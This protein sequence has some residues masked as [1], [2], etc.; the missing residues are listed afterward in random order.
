[1]GGGMGYGGGSVGGSAAAGISA[2]FQMGREVDNDADRR[3]QVARENA[4]QDMLDNERQAQ[5]TRNNTRQDAEDASNQNVRAVAAINGEMEDNRFQLANLA[6]KYGGAANVPASLAAPFVSQA[7]DISQRRTALLQQI[8]APVV[9]REQQWA[10]DTSSRIAAG[11]ISM[12]SLSPADTVRLYQATTRR[13]VSDFLRPDTNDPAVASDIANGVMSGNSVV[14]QGIADSE[15]GVQSGNASLAAR[16]A[17]T[18]TAPEVSQGVGHIATDGSQITGKTISALVPAP[19]A[20]NAT[21]PAPPGGVIG[22]LGAALNGT[23]PATSLPVSATSAS[24]PGGLTGAAADASNPPA[25][26]DNGMGGA[27]DTPVAATAGSG[28]AAPAAAGSPVPAQAP[29]PTGGVTGAAPA[30][31]PPPPLVQ[32]T[33]PDRVI[34]VLQVTA[35]HPDGTTVQYHAPMTVNRSTDPND[36]IHPGV[37]ISGAMDHMGQLG[38]LEALANVP[39]MRAKIEQG[40]KDLGGNVNDFT[41]AYAAMHGDPNALQPKG[42]TDPTTVKIAAVQAFAKANGLSFADAMQQVEGKTPGGLTGQMGE[43]HTQAVKDGLSDEAEAKK[44]QGMGVLRSPPNEGGPKAPAGYAYKPDGTLHFIP[45]GPADPSVKGGAA[46]LG[47][48]EAVFINRTLT[49]ANEATKDLQNVVNLPISA[50]TGFFGG[51]TQGPGI[52]DAGKE[53]LTNTLT[54]QEVQSFN[55]RTAGFHRALAG[56]ESAG[57]APSGTLSKQMDAVIGKQGDTYQTQLEKLGEIRQIVEAG[58]ETTLANPKLP[59]QQATLARTIIGRIRQAVPFTIADI[60]KLQA[61]QVS[62]PNA[63]MTDVIK[64][65]GLNKGG[66]AGSNGMPKVTDQASY[67]AVPPRSQY[68]APDGSTRTKQ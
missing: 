66:G 47:A 68:I 27:P 46:I 5:T 22:A 61:L 35:Q 62:D 9:Q 45:G 57:L 25:S 31:P 30:P 2:G 8:Y 17:T 12:D 43:I 59:E 16:G 11:Q 42:A 49:A 55:V 38:T 19:Q 20:P 37:S 1:M 26:A 41:S 33:D 67:D 50:N 40:Q 34:P 60:D 52:L 63:T 18:L 10:Q 6:S 13:P 24:A 28:P 39:A 4:R 32:G 36:M 64:A 29:S 23:A 53:A 15:A 14:G 48:R 7:Q 56:I 58:L 65:N 54:S 44:M 3:A 21:P 51:R